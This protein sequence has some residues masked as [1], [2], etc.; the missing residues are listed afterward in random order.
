[1][2]KALWRTA[3]R[4]SIVAIATTLV[5][6][7]PAIGARQIERLDRG[8]TAV[9]AIGGTGILVS[10]RLL[11]T[12][13]A[14][15]GF[16]LYR[17]GVKLNAAPLTGATNFRDDG[18]TATST[19]A[20]KVV[21]NGREQDRAFTARVWAAG[22]GTIPIQQPAGGT[23]PDG[24]AYTYTANDASVGDLD[25]DG[26]YEIVL[27]WDPTNSK[28]NSQSGY[29]G[30]VLLDAYTLDG[31]RLWRIDLGRNIRAGAHYTQFQV[32]DYDGD[33]RAEVVM[34]TADGTVDGEGRVI[35]NASADF[36]NTAGYVL[37]GPEYL[38][39]FQGATGR[40]LSTVKYVPGRHPNTEN[41][42]GAQLSA[43]WGDN[44]GNR[45]DRFLAGTAYFDGAR[46]SIVMG[47]GY[48]TRSTV[49]AWDFRNGQLVQ[50]WFF[51]S[52]AQ[53]V[54]S[55]YTGQGNHNLSIADVDGDGRDEII[56]GSMAIDDD[57]TAMWTA[58]V[59]NIK[60]GHGDALH[61]GDL[62]PNRP[63]LER[64]G[65]HED[66]AGNGGIAATMMDA[67]TGQVLWTVSGNRDN[68]RG[69]SADIDPRYAGEENWS[70][71]HTG[72]MTAAGQVISAAKPAQT[73]FA[74]WWD[75]D[76]LRELL[77]GTTISKW[78]WTTGTATTL[79]NMTGT[80]S[81]NGTKATPA[82]AADIL[83]DWRE[84]VVMAAAD[85]QSL[86]IYATPYPTETRLPTLMHDP[87]YRAS[88]AW[89]NTAYN[90]PTHTG[91]YLGETTAP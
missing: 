5:A 27:K 37:A 21:V 23:T 61:V 14:G 12:D 25:G 2:S 6:A 89:Q 59:N 85:N 75:G 51:D 58:K 8:V 34:K 49:A 78:N 81:A 39:A 56:Y 38:T 45:V 15:T 55:N 67:R 82:L 69:V 41:P 11:S 17:D 84:E 52:S 43:I 26:R 35:G 30:P 9:P 4:A 31:R 74:I 71:R 13:A 76:R 18:G 46:P 19:Y 7:A 64:F 48:Y 88:V 91:F 86:R 40:A 47:R 44:Y 33:G 1:M 20:I 50:R 60:V 22:Y 70:A 72:L 87:V 62:D 54:P 63:G 79:L 10:W 65:V 24:V 90:Q 73:N 16:N 53:G 80:I 68:G 42:T 32:Q 83:G 77:D 28:D 3:A 66:F 36:R 29:T 57:G